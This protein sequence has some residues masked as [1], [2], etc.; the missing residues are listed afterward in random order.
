[1]DVIDRPLT[2]ELSR[3][4]AASP[5]RVFDAWTTPEWA[6]WLG[7]ATIRS[8]VLQMD[9]RP[10]GTYRLRV[11]RPDGTITESTGTYHEVE[12]PHRLVMTFG[13]GCS[14]VE[15]RLTVTFHADGDGTLMTLYQEGFPDAGLRGNFHE[16]WGGTGA[17]FDKLERL[18]S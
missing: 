5:K 4:F 17:S 9:P 14:G 16:G 1:M 8:E 18:L 11:F 2:L 6:E 13:A 7:P 3:R 10:G 12:R 15:T